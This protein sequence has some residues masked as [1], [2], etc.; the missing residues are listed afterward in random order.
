MAST[1]LAYISK[2]IHWFF[3]LNFNTTKTYCERQINWIPCSHAAYRLR[4]N[5]RFN[6]KAK[7]TYPA[8]LQCFQNTRDYK[9]GIPYNCEYESICKQ[10][11]R[12]FLHLPW[13]NTD[14]IFLAWMIELGQAPVYQAKFSK[15]M[16]YHY[17]VGLDISMHN[18]LRMAII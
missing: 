17:I 5:R 3:C 1:R 10:D 15:F 12:S 4:V 18:A 2:K 9:D 16:V 13:C 8:N 11:V 14:I 7:W 6:K